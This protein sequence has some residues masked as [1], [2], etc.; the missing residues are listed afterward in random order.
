MGGVGEGMLLVHGLITEVERTGIFG[1]PVQRPQ[2]NRG[3]PRSHRGEVSMAPAIP[4]GRWIR[5][6]RGWRPR[7][8]LQLPFHPV[9]SLGW[10][11]AFRCRAILEEAAALEG[12]T[13]SWAV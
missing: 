13:W 3:M 8:S 12:R 10:Y 4:P 5:S 2:H 11:Q 9:G 1:G 6:S 7:C